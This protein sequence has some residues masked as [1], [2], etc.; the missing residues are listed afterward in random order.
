MTRVLILVH[1]YLLDEFGVERALRR[2]R[3]SQKPK[4]SNL[5]IK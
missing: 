3:A 4:K 5:V 1:Q 2:N